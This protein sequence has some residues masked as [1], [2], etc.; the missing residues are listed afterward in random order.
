M[1]NNILK[2]QSLN[3]SFPNGNGNY[4][5]VIKNISFSVSE[6]E[7]VLIMGPSGSGKTTL[8]SIIGCLLP[9]SSGKVYIKGSDIMSLNQNKLSKFR[10]ANIGFIFQSFRLLNSLRVIDNVALVLELSGIK[11]SLAKKESY[12]VLEEVCISER[13]DYY[14]DKL[15]GGEKQRV[16]VARSLVSGPSIILADEPTGSLDSVSGQNIIEILSKLAKKKKKTVVVVSHD[17]RIKNYA[18]R[19]FHIEDGILDEK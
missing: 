10:L 3:K 19:L 9:A 16:A 18:D 6:G 8:L 13:A 2:V 1:N 15:S 5:T 4:L 7:F 11:G 12:K 14:P 17:E